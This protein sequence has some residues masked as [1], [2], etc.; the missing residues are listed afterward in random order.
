[1][2]VERAALEIFNE[3]VYDE[4][5]ANLALNR[6][7]DKIPQESMAYVRALIYTAL[8]HLRH[9]D[10]IAMHFAKG[11]Q[12]KAI[13]SII[14]LGV[15]QIVFMKR[16]NSAVC[17]EYVKLTKEIGK[18][19]LSGYVNG[20]LRSVSRAA[21][22]GELPKLPKDKAEA[23]SIET[24]YPKWLVEEYIK[25]FGEVKTRDILTYRD[26]RITVRAQ[27]PYTRDELEEWC[28]LKGVE[29]ERGR[30]CEDMLKLSN[31]PDITKDDLFLSGKLTIQSESSAVVCMACDIKKGMRIL[32][33]CAAPGG[34]SAYMASIAEN[35][36]EIVACELH[37]HR[38][39]LMD[40]TFNRLNIACAQT[41][42]CDMTIPTD[43]FNN[44]FDVVLCDVPC[45]GLGVLGKPD[46]RYRKD[47][48]AVDAI[49]QTQG[50]ILNNCSKY[51]KPGGSLIYST[52]TVS[53]RENE[54]VIRSFL[55]QHEDFQL[56]MGL[57]ELLPIEGDRA[58]RGMFHIL[59]D[60]DG[61]DAFFIAKLRKG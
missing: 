42:T 34:K 53:I 4:A 59:P 21:E 52:C 29:Y 43:K 40:N 6:A 58:D 8:E 44:S 49:A 35:C 16:Q 12:N 39:V 30:I 27:Y 48:E 47:A 15:C 7:Q 46:A 31:A 17:N 56:D 24:G 33:A 26:D 22:G 11:R 23:L 1:M 36:C 14:R 18:G 61:M 32:D 37:E 45:S 28:R 57:S 3:I 13:K 41:E 10:Y 19:A 20:V 9:I 55:A 50:D 25:R 51:V 5:Y 54:E 38:K 60:R 2:S